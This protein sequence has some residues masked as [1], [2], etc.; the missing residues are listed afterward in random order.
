MELSIS[1]KNRKSKHYLLITW[2]I[3]ISGAWVLPRE[4]WFRIFVILMN[5]S[6]IFFNI[7]KMKKMLFRSKKSAIFLVMIFFSLLISILINGDL[8]SW[9]TYLSVYVIIITAY[10]IAENIPINVFFKTFS[11]IITI[12]AIISLIFMLIHPFLSQMDLSM[13]SL[14]IGQSSAYVNL[15]VYLY[16]LVGEY[17]NTGVFWE[18]GAYQV[19][20]N[21]T[22]M[23]LLLFEK[24]TIKNILLVMII[25][26]TVFTTKST[27]GYLVIL[28]ILVMYLSL[29]KK[30]K[31]NYI[32]SLIVLVFVVFVLTNDNI[33]ANIQEKIFL[34]SN[35][36]SSL[37]R[38]YS[39]LADLKMITTSPLF[40]VGFVKYP[41]LL[42][43]YAN[44]IGYYIVVNANTFT[45][46]GAIYGVFFTFFI[47]FG[48]YRYAAKHSESLFSKFLM[49]FV[50]VTLFIAQNFIDKAIIYVLIF[51]GLK[52]DDFHL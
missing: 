13:F 25:S 31:S 11:K 22:L 39:T 52:D 21:I 49:F 43:Q 48:L 42:I 47:L 30:S 14:V 19:F 1:K 46:S 6:Y 29:K 12:I 7:L 4:N 26:V 32:F 44:Y 9:L 5:T 28:L 16:P 45:Y 2:I 10:F 41:E 24:K 17:R 51:Y 8:A 3:L 34:F 20:L 33:M 35:Y 27:H 40:G 38:Y 23:H 36:T 50:L 15:L 37:Q 18:P